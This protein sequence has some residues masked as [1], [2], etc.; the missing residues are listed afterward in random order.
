MLG[1]EEARKELAFWMQVQRG[2]V[3]VSWLREVHGRGYAQGGKLVEMLGT[4]SAGRPGLP[5]NVYAAD[6]YLFLAE[7]SEVIVRQ[8]HDPTIELCFFGCGGLSVRRGHPTK[9]SRPVEF[10]FGPGAYITSVEGL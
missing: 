9:Y 7:A 3:F 6:K 1:H 8:S 10:G 2:H 4:P 5:D